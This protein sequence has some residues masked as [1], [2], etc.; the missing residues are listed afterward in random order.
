MA[1]KQLLV[2]RTQVALAGGAN[3]SADTPFRSLQEV[4]NHL[5]AIK[6]RVDD[7]DGLMKHYELQ[8]SK[9]NPKMAAK[10]ASEIIFEVNPGAGG[11]GGVRKPKGPKITLDKIDKVV[12]PRIETLRKNFILVDELSDKVD[13]LDKLYNQVSVSFRS[14]RG[15]GDMLKS[16]KTLQRAT[17]SKLQD[18]LAFLNSVGERHVPTLFRQ[19]VEA[20]MAYVQPELDF[21][22]H[23][24]LVYAYEKG[25]DLAFAVYIQLNDLTDDAGETYPKFYIVFNCVLAATGKDQVTPT[26]YLTVMHDFATP[27]KYGLGKKISNPADA[28]QALGLMLEMENVNTGIGVM[29]HNLDPAKVNKGKF[30]SGAKVSAIK[31][32][33]NTL[34]FELLK[35]VKAAEANEIA[36]T[37]YVDVKGMLTHIKGAKLKIKVTSEAGRIVVK[38][39]LTNLA[40]EN[41]VSLDDVDFLRDNFGLDDAKLRKVIQIMNDES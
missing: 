1:I 11:K 27:G 23:K 17:S 19:I 30:R 29:P 15:G 16:I 41:Q 4:I 34:T 32:D 12:I 8:F 36:K 20:T 31:V 13:E 25:E 5:K 21:K 7:I 24:T 9:A 14:V 22:S 6:V 35:G 3:D 37:L 38:F 18:A 39:T 2:K 28:S 40:K 26:Y 33:P 10:A